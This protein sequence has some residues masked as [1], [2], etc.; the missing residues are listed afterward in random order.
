MTPDRGEAVGS[1]ASGVLA[2]ERVLVPRHRRHL[3]PGRARQLKLRYSQEEF[4]ELAAAASRAGLTT[5]GYAA[6]AALAAARDAAPPYSEPWREAL[7]EVMAARAQVRRF[8]SN[9]NQA[10]RELN[11][12]GSAPEWLD[13]AVAVT[14]RAVGRLDAAAADLTRRLPG[15]KP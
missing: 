8:G 7:A 10:V 5:S 6:E 9:V 15:S 1:T 2:C 3:L 4:R 14:E 13:R 11:A 12:T